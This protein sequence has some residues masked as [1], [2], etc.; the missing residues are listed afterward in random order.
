[1]S[2]SID[3]IRIYVQ[4]DEQSGSSRYIAKAYLDGKPL[5]EFGKHGGPEVYD[6]LVKEMVAWLKGQEH[7]APDHYLAREWVEHSLPK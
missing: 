6:E 1:M 7:Q 4:P 5:H 2:I 3:G